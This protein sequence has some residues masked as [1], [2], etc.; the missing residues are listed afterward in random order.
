M[1]T[2]TKSILSILKDGGVSA[3]LIAILLYFGSQFLTSISSIQTDLANI[4]MELVKIQASII[5]QEKIQKIV[6]QK[7]EKTVLKYHANGR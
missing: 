2:S 6:D 4:K 5:T 7:I 1:E 3:A